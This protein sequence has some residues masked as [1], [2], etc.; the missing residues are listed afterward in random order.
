VNVSSIGGRLGISQEK[1]VAVSP[2]ERTKLMDEMRQ[3][4]EDEIKAKADMPER[5][6]TDV[7]V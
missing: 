7:C 2:A 5:T 4:L 1:F 3:V 6:K